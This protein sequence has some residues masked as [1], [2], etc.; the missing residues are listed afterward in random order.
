[1][2][3]FI[4]IILFSLIFNTARTFPDNGTGII[5]EWV[6]YDTFSRLTGV[7]WL[8]CAALNQYL[9]GLAFVRNVAHNVYHWWGRCSNLS[10]VYMKREEGFCWMSSG[11]SQLVQGS[12][13]SLSVPADNIVMDSVKI[14]YPDYGIGAFYHTRWSYRFC[15]VFDGTVLCK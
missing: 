13:G 14:E 9:S 6:S 5:S 8:R 11:E 12:N 10:A 3:I 4:I 7:S 15:L 2:L 1:M